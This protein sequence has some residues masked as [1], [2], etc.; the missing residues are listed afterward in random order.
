[1]KKIFIATGKISTAKF[2]AAK[3]KIVRALRLSGCLVT[4]PAQADL[5]L[6]LGGDGTML[7]AIGRYR[8]N[9]VPFCGLN[10]G[11]IGFLMNEYDF[12][13]LDA[14]VSNQLYYINV[15]L[16]QAKLYNQHNKKIGLTYAFND[17]YL[18]RISTNT[19][20][21]KISVNKTVYLNPLIADGVIV[22][23]AAGSTGYN[24]SAG[25][26]MLPFETNSLQVAGICP[27]I[28]HQ[29]RSS[30][31]SADSQVT[32]EAR[33]LEKRPVRLVGDG[34]E[35]QDTVKAK[36]SYSNQHVSLAFVHNQNFRKK[37]MDLQF[38]K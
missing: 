23:S 28:F 1:M 11:H 27:A 15:P 30:L 10:F 25:G 34:V 8:V 21:I 12:S 18:E 19:A 24:A 36:I 26:V 2:T 7:K 20:K 13:I 6:V 4:H 31:L 32:I 17:F 5:I 9:N 14:I 37:V 22:S 35:I 29:W 16:L 3:E 33:E 38:R